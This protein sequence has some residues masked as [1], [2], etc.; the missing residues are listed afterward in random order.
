MTLYALSIRRPVLATVMSLVIVIFGVIGFFFL[1]VREYPTIDPATITVSTSYR[2][3]NVDVIN[4]QITE[5]LEEEING[6]EGIRTITSSSREGGSN[7]TIEF[8][9]G[10]DLERAAND[11]RDRV[12]R[13]MRLLPQDVDPPVVSKADASSGYVVFLR[14][15]SPTRNLLD[16]TDLADNQI[17]ERVQ[18]IPGVARVD[19]WGEK[20]YAMRMWLDP[21]KLAAFSLTPIDVQ[22]ALQRSNIE[23][24]S[25]RI[26]GDEVEL[27]VR[28]QSRLRTVEDFNNLIIKQN[29]ASIVRFQDLGRAELGSENERT[30]MRSDGEPMVGVVLRPLPNANYIEIVDEFYRR[31][32]SIRRDMPSDVTLSI[33]FDTTTSIRQSIAEVQETIFIAMLLVVMV[34]FFFLRDWRSTFIPIIVIPISLVGAFFIMYLFGFSINILTLLAIVLAIGIVVDDAIVVLENI[35]AKMEAGHEPV[36][37]GILG[38]REIFMPVVATTF[39][40]V[41]V[42]MPI[43]FLGGLTGKLF[44]E[45]GIVIAGSVVIS[46]FVALTLT[47]MLATRLLKGH[48]GH[49][50][51][52]QRTEP[53]FQGLLSGYQRLLTRFMR[54]RWIA[55]VVMVVSILLSVLIYRS[56]PA[57]LAPM[58]DR[59]RLTVQ[60]TAPEGASYE[61]MDAFMNQLSAIVE[62]EVPEKQTF[63]ALTSPGFGGGVNAGFMRM[64]LVPPEERERSQDAIAGFL[65]RRLGGLTGAR[66]FVTQEQTISVGRRGGLPVQYVIQAPNFEKLKEAL[67]R[68]L[69]TAQRD[70][71]FAFVDVDLKFNKPE[72]QITINRERA[73][74]LGVSVADVAQTLQLALSE[75]RMGYFIQNGQQYQVIAQV[76]R[77]N[78]N[79]TVDLRSLYVR[80]GGGDPVPLDNLVTVAEQSSPPQMY[81]F[82]RFI[83]ATVSAQLAPGFTIGDGIEAMDRVAAATLDESFATTLTGTSRDFQESSNSLLFVFVLAIVFIYLV[84]AAQFESFR[85]PFTIMLTVPLALTGALVF[86][87]YFNQTL[88]IFSQIGMIMLIG[89]V[90]K[91]GILIV[92]FANQRREAGLS[93][94]EAVIDASVAR[95]RPV[96]MT[97]FS[98]ILGIL[99]IAL[100]LGA[101]AESRVPMGIAVIGGLSIGTLLTLFVIP[102]IYTYLAGRTVRYSGAAGDGMGEAAASAPALAETTARPQ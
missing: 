38:T 12:S 13:A 16:L 83:S 53:F 76:Y 50:R 44:R 5:P 37:A 8:E 72:L 71:T 77:D 58:E 7:I 101:G 9:L 81:R 62:S 31:L 74:L 46:A 79:A 78:R 23:L 4:S 51:L 3:A 60:A 65:T 14:V 40:L 96:L 95:L 56:L 32:E 1:G 99:P 64:N 90:A 20:R 52:Y 54:V 94:Q 92:E 91:N 66:V 102:A 93:V 86:L 39:A 82:N 30:I 67:P 18:T 98:T 43:I 55:P 70:E 87:W 21:Q 61:Y 36:E 47:P 97:T 6:I 75:Q 15:Q 89:L 42:F 24:P 49:S 63:V 59:S 33:G 41:S 29:D 34:I 2:G 69:E 73:E 35:Y 11:V 100:A 68:F 57:E 26:E 25:G 27:T 48:T 17:K 80:T 84:L 22:R 85:D 10:A 19:I 28:T 45:F 88:N